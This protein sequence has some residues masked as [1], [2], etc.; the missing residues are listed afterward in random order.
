ML[1]QELIL[2]TKLVP[3]QAPRHTLAR[4]RLQELLAQALDY[5][6]TIVQAGTG[7]GK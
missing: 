7:Y 6:L 2:R 5:R 3:P 4:P 1:R